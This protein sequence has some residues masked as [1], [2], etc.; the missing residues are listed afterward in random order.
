[1]FQEY[2]QRRRKLP[3]FSNA[4]SIRNALDRT[5]L[6]QASRLYSRM[7][8]LLSREELMTIEAED[9]ISSRVFDD[10]IDN[11]DLS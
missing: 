11:Q 7:G 9:I 3:F 8:H 5:R 2:I 4:R 6:R 10:E 1:M